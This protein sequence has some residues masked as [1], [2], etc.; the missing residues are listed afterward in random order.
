[1]FNMS[2]I[3]NICSLNS[4]SSF[5]YDKIDIEI[6]LKFIRENKNMKKMLF[7]LHI[8]KQYKYLFVK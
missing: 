3:S 8:F 7:N 5:K 6:K 2:L 4:N 1:M